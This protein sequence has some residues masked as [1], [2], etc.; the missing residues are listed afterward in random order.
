M[1]KGLQE[2]EQKQQRLVQT[3]LD[4]PHYWWRRRQSH[5]LINQK[6]ALLSARNAPINTLSLQFIHPSAFRLPSE[7]T[8]DAARRGD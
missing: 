8:R 2:V 1:K 4:Q 5:R 3:L 7:R 6:V